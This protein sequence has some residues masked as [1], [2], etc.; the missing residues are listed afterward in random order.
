MPDISA[1]IHV[2]RQ[3]PVAPRADDAVQ[4]R[5]A[6]GAGCAERHEEREATSVAL[7]VLINV[8]GI[9][10]YYTR[11][12]SA[13]TTQRLAV[14]SCASRWFDR[15]RFCV[16]GANMCGCCCAGRPAC[17]L[18]QPKLAATGVARLRALGF[19]E[20]AF[21]RMSED[22]RPQA[23]PVGTKSRHGSVRCRNSAS[24][25]DSPLRSQPNA[26]GPAP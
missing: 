26:V 11:T 24:L 20:A 8:A 14:Q 10:R 16:E 22:W 6:D 19:G 2:Y 7:L 5:L 18:A 25:G 3:C 1:Q 4:H 15:R 17:W 9:G 13:T 12:W 21:M 23:F